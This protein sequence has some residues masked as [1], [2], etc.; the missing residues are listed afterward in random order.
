MKK[1]LLFITLNLLVFA[2]V[3]INNALVKDLAT[4]KGVGVK[5]AEVIVAYRKD[6]CFKNADELTKIKGIGKKIVQKNRDEIVV[7]ECKN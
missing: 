7:G 3:D 6:H 4:L 5:K 1:L 2:S